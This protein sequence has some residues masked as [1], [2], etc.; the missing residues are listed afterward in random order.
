MTKSIF[1][2][3][4][5]PAQ[6]ASILSD[7]HLRS[8]LEWTRDVLSAS[9]AL[10]GIGDRMLGVGTK[11]GGSL[12]TWAAKDWDNFMWLVFYGMA[13]VE[14]HDR[15]FG[16]MHDAMTGIFVAGNLGH[17]LHDG[18]PMIPADWPWSEAAEG[19]SHFNA[20]NAYQNVLRDECEAAADRDHGP[21]W[22][23]TYPPNWLADTGEVVYRD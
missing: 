18:E 19:Y 11:H 1:I 16:T 6:C 4:E 23:N 2:I 13:L 9:L 20:F 12:A 3:D 10:R 8:Q 15:R 14:E 21:T 5:D 17:L 7:Q 22:T